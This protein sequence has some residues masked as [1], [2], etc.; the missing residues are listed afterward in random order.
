MRG[1]ECPRRLLLRENPLRGGF[2][3]ILRHDASDERP[4]RFAL[5]TT[6]NVD[7]GSRFHD[8]ALIHHGHAVTDFF[9][10]VHLVRNH[11]DR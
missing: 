5:G 10:D 9:D 3:Q 7:H 4:C 2:R 1:F 6:E 8:H 11:D